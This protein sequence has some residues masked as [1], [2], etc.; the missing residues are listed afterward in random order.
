MASTSEQS[1]SVGM[2]QLDFSN[3]DNQAFWLLTFL[4]LVFLVIRLLVMPRMEETLTNRRK[5]IEE[6][7][8]EA[9][10]F[11]DKAVEIEN[12][13]NDEIEAARTKANEILRN[14]KE[15]IKRNTKDALADIDI[16][17]EELAEKSEKN[18]VSLKFEAKKEVNAL[19][20]KLAPEIVKALIP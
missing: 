1:S 7:I 16:K 10:D 15:E 5:I 14:C 8:Q 13:L 20:K 18:I 11:R 4:F 19:S 17:I 12:S 3:F 2:P 6:G 9:E